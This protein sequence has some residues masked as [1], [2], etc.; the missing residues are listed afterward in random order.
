MLAEAGIGTRQQAFLDFSLASPAMRT[1]L[2]SDG[3]GHPVGTALA[4]HF[5]RT[6]WIGNVA[7]RPEARRQGLGMWLTEACLDWLHG[8]GATSVRLLASEMGVP[9]YR[10]L[11]F[12]NEGNAYDKYRVARGLLSPGRAGL[13]VEPLD[14]DPA[15]LDLLWEFDRTLTGEDRTP[16]LTPFSDRIGIMRESGGDASGSRR[17]LGYGLRL[18]WG[19]GCVLARTR[20]AGKELWHW[21]YGVVSDGPVRWAVPAGVEEQRA[22]ASRLGLAPDG[23]SVRMRYDF[24]SASNEA[25]SK[26]SFGPSFRPEAIWA[27]WSLAVG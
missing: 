6:G 8:R 22:F 12:V 2:A 26:D 3:A 4:V 24:A 25:D 18:P 11:G 27:V 5:G 16:L 23:Q 1:F 9:V 10:R 19:G 14:P 20:E 7:V 17:L 21:V 15:S 13:L